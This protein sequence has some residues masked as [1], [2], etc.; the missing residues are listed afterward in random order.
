MRPIYPW[1]QSLADIQQE[2]KIAGQSLSQASIQ[3]SSRN[4][5]QIKSGGTWKGQCIP[6]NLGLL[7]R[8]MFSLIKNNWINIIYHINRI[9]RKPIS[10]DVE[11]TFDKIW[12]ALFY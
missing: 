9:K 4:Y 8:Y 3:I 1:H 6:S 10:I 2:K 11:N 12:N 7:Q 5:Y